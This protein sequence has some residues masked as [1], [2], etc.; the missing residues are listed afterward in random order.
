MYV[1]FHFA[2]ENFHK[3]YYKYYM[4]CISNA[5]CAGF[6]SPTFKSFLDALNNMKK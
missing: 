4:Y 2:E 6:E 3:E 5:N 1:H